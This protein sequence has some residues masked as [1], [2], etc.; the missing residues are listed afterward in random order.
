MYHISPMTDV[1]AVNLSANGAVWPL[2]A[3]LTKTNRFTDAN[4]ITM[5]VLV[6]YMYVRFSAASSAA[7]SPFALSY[8]AT[9]GISGT[10]TYAAGLITAF[11]G[12]TVTANAYAAGDYG[13]VQVGGPN[14]VAMSAAAAIAQFARVEHNGAA[15][16]VKTVAT[17]ANT[18]GYLIGPAIGGAGAIPIGS[19]FLGRPWAVPL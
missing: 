14:T 7:G 5:D 15:F 11:C 13:W 3:K 6:T 8:S 9:Y 19:I 1:T 16:D 12:I 4:S 17:D 2:G 10:T 18:F